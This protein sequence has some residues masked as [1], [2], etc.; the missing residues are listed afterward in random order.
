MSRYLSIILLSLATLI[1]VPS[2]S[3]TMSD[4][5]M[6]DDLY[7][8]ENSDV[9]FTGRLIGKWQGSF[10][11]GKK[12]GI[13]K[14]YHDNGQLWAKGKNTNGKRD[15]PW[16]SFWSNGQLEYKGD[17]KDNKRKGPW[18]EY[19]NNGKLKSEVGGTFKNGVKVLD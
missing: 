3:E 8:R 7:F 16:V 1:A 2:Y 19:H 17:Y 6:R 12:V 18:L 11:N 4:L 10:K 5:D 14:I 13:W 15:G 9:P